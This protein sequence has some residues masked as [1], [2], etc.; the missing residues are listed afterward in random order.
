MILKR[1]WSSHVNHVL[2]IHMR[3]TAAVRKC[4][5]GCEHSQNSRTV[6]AKR[7]RISWRGRNTLCSSILEHAHTC[8]SHSTRTNKR[9]H[10]AAIV[11]LHT[12][13]SACCTL[14]VLALFPSLHLSLSIYLSTMIVVRC[15]RNLPRNTSDQQSHI[16]VSYDIVNTQSTDQ[17]T[18]EL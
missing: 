16:F 5:A 10:R 14:Y 3:Q 9:Q 2:E 18:T 17:R 13:I 7:G 1:S 4:N 12:S 15:A 11:A 8:V 6:L